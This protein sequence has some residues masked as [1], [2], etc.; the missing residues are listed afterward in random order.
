MLI[1]EREKLQFAVGYH[2]ELRS[3]TVKMGEPLDEPGLQ[4]AFKIMDFSH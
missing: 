2:D 3:F 4:K 1:G